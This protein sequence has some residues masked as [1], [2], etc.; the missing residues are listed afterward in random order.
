M[1][2]SS[3]AAVA[4]VLPLEREKKKNKFTSLYNKVGKDIIPGRFGNER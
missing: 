4:K 3:N 1:D 2:V